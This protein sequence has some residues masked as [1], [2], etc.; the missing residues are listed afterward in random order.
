MF[1]R[2]LIA[3]RGE[4]A[5]RI[6][7]AC[8]E[9][10]IEAVAVYSTADAESAHVAAA[11]R[12][13]R[14]GPPDPRRSYLSIPS[15]I[16]A[17][18]MTG[19]EA[20]HPGYGFLAE[21]S[22]FARACTDNDLAF[23]GPTPESM[24][25]LG[26]KSLAKRIMSD[27]GLPTIPGTEGVLADV[28]EARSAADEVG[29]P[30]M[31]K[32]SAGGGGRGMRLVETP[33]ALERS[34]QA[35][36]AEAEGAFG[37]G[38]LYLEKVIVRP[39]HVE[40]QVIGD[41][42]GAA[43][44]LGERD[45]SIQRRHQKVLEESPSPLLDDDTRARLL[46]LVT[47]ACGAIR[48][49]SAGTLEFLADEH[50]DFYFMEMNTRV[51]VEHPVSEMVTGVDVIKT[52]IQVA[53]GDPLPLTGSI[54]PQGH[55]MEFRIN[56]EDP[57]KDF[58]PRGGKIERLRLPLGP[59]VRVDTHLYEGYRVPTNYD[60]LLAK[61]IV[62][63]RDRPSCIARGLRCLGELEIEGVP[64]TRDLHMDILRHPRFVAGS[65]STAFLEEAREE[66]ATL[67]GGAN[68]KGAA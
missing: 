43:L 24:D 61:V 23:I 15:L 7:R 4:I 37:N 31:L 19:C 10:D 57:A 38:D 42:Q 33:A 39:H 34:Y 12:A 63:D 45:C 3:N 16:A 27:A 1:G 5:V 2:I 8:H 53:A 28:G 65:V 40:V 13:V 41:G 14:L 29:Y 62:W 32:A 36:S 48:Y 26:D 67:G 20:V 17:A 47:K 21:N 54:T 60:S 50:R 18:R 49:L 52:Q 30:V 11:D 22:A 25:S 59:G 44:T 66:L 9:L 58:M 68:G 56:A 35:A 6:V 55:A 51:Q 64:T 46:V